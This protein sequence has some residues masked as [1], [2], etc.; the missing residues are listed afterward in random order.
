MIIII[1]IC[2]HIHTVYNACHH[3]DMYTCIHKYTC[4]H[5][6]CHACMC[7]FDI[8]IINIYLYV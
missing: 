2:T 7:A 3:T 1:N 8:I 6:Y 4:I 5:Y